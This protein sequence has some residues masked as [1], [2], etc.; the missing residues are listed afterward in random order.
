L[1]VD[2]RAAY[3]ETDKEFTSVH[4]ESAQEGQTEVFI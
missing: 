4:T 2:E 1:S 3:L